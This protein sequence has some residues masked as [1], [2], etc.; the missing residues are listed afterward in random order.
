MGEDI[1]SNIAKNYSDQDFQRVLDSA[2]SQ[3]VKNTLIASR[4]LAKE[5]QN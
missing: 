2:K 5:E 3:E 4:K 1:F